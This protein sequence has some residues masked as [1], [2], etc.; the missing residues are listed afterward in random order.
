M[1]SNSLHP[2]TASG[3]PIEQLNAELERGSSDSDMQEQLEVF[4]DKQEVQ[5]RR[6]SL[7]H[8]T[9]PV[10]PGAKRQKTS[11]FVHAMLEAK[12]KAGHM[13]P[14]QEGLAQSQP[15]DKDTPPPPY[16]MVEHRQSRLLTKK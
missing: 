16:E 13:T 5:R 10:R 8:E 4:F 3:E 11:C 14:N 9:R 7:A 6:A 1:A 15:S 2:E 12:V